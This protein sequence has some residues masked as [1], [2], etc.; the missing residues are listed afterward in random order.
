MRILLK[1][2]SN[3]S[4]PYSK[5]STGSLFREKQSHVR[6]YKPD[7]VI[8]FKKHILGHLDNQNIFFNFLFRFNLANTFCIISFRGRIQ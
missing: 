3:Q 5:P 4:T 7:I 2:K 6:V 1:P 8:Y